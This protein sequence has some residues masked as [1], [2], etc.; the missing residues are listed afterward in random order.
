MKMLV[1]LCLC[2]V[3]AAESSLAQTILPSFSLG[4][5]LSV[6]AGDFG[7][8]GGEGAGFAMMG[9]AVTGD[10]IFPLGS[11]LGWVTSASIVYNPANDDI[12]GG[13]NG[14]AG[15]WVNIPFLTGLRYETP[16]SPSASLF[17]QG[18]VG[19]NYVNGPDIELSAGGQQ[20]EV[21]FGGATTFGF[22][23]GAG[24]LIN[25][26]IGVSA[27]YF[28]MGEA[29][30]EIEIEEPG[31]SSEAEVDRPVS[32]FQIVLSYRLR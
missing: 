4:V 23:I 6:P 17:G 18:Q 1:L 24:V 2:L 7:D 27:R 26:R 32:F 30:I 25:Q 8:D 31:G 11:S 20:G 3:V 19:F 15:P 28:D 22:G 16:I 13:A 21:N 29:E 12:L 5:G 10:Y 9:I 14:D